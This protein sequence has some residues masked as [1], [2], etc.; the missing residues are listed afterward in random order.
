ME[1]DEKWADLHIHTVKSDGTFTVEDVFNN[2]KK[3]GASAI[4]I[5]D[6][7]T[8]SAIEDAL[9]FEKLYQIE[10]I[11]GVE[12]SAIQNEREVHIVGLYIN[13]K[14]KTFLERL[15]EFQKVR[16]ERAK[17]I[18]KKLKDS[19]I[20]I[21]FEELY[22][23]TDNMNNAGRLHIARLLYEKNIVRSV[24]EA[25]DRFLGE[26]KPAYVEKE[27][28]TVKDAIDII[29]KMGGIAILAHPY[30]LQAD[31][32]ILKWKEQGLDGLEAYHPDHP[33]FV[34]AKYIDLAK[35]NNL[36]VSGGSDC[37]GNHR[38][39]GRIGDIRLPYEYLAEIK[40]HYKKVME[41]K[42]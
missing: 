15:M 19:G 7:D 10:F 1:K 16:V 13:W 31:D 4:A 30:H 37:H 33:Y 14:D 40:G 12:L 21:K 29:K 38:D 22:E 3:A 23:I 11:P 42:I 20:K 32:I 8:V 24:K 35:K 36:L 34:S 2:A 39:Y 41:N 26:G 17:K 18:I 27:R 5:T 9:F 25:F 28:I 6:H